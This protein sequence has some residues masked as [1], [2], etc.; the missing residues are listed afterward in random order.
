[1]KIKTKEFI[2]LL[3][4]AIKGVSNNKLIPITSMMSIFAHD[5]VVELHTTDGSNHLWVGGL[6]EDTSGFEVAVPATKF[7]TLISRM[8]CEY[9]EL[10][11]KG[12]NLEVKG[13]GRYIIELPIDESGEPVKFPNP[14]E[15][16]NTLTTAKTINTSDIVAVKNALSPA[17]ATTLE[18]PCYCNYYFGDKVIATDTYKIAAMNKQLFE[19]VLLSPELVNLL[20]LTDCETLEYNIIGNEIY[21]NADDI[22]VYGHLA[23]GLEDYAIDAITNLINDDFPYECKVDK[24]K[25]LSSLDR[26]A[27]FVDVYDKNAVKIV[28]GN[29]GLTIESRKAHSEEHIV[30]ERVAEIDCEFSCSID[31]DMFISQL[32]AYTEDVVTI[33]FGKET[34][35]KLVSKDTTQI[36]SLLDV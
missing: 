28:F 16:F 33:Q 29:L 21:F 3:S 9:V 23:D 2:S 8:T 20:A 25:L 34:S 19:P 11:I 1:M 27:L 14:A 36:I 24:D 15:K 32:K 35:I 30:Y 22:S 4:K 26:T 10:I 18:V 6:C 31:V 13:N 7:A 12:D 17:L 5:N